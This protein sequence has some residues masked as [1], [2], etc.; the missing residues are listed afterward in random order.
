MCDVSPH[1][2]HHHLLPRLSADGPEH[3][4]LAPGGP[5]DADSCG[6]RRLQVAKSMDITLELP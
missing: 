5:Q 1:V 2:R 4:V 3:G 6:S